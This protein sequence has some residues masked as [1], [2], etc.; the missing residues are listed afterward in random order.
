MT[1]CLSLSSFSGLQAR[2]WIGIHVLDYIVH[3][4]ISSYQTDSQITRILDTSVL[5]IMPLVNP[6]G[7]EYSRSELD[8]RLWRKNRSLLSS[9]KFA[10]SAAVGVNLD[11]NFPAHWG[12]IDGREGAE[13][14]NPLSSMFR[15]ETP[16]SEKEVQAI[17]H[18]FQESRPRIVAALDLRSYGPAILRP[19][20]S[21]QTETPFLSARLLRASQTV[22]S[23]IHTLHQKDYD[24]AQA[25]AIGGPVYGS[26]LD[27]AFNGSTNASSSSAYAF[28]IELRDGH[29]TQ[30]SQLQDQDLQLQQPQ[31][32]HQQQL[33]TAKQHREREWGG[34][35]GS[36]SQIQP[37]GDEVLKG[38]LW[39]LRFTLDS[40]LKS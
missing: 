40:P 13:L 32:Q 36:C 35:V 9:S 19:L 38:L 20:S 39:L 17:V 4:I 8:R 23:L 3:E 10:S 12:P 27:F 22:S 11:R 21:M 30:N 18:W 1:P 34:L 28:A 29:F 37:T 5:Y 33:S 2:D 15:G 6:D 16:G 25:G 31:R 26:W 7:Y 14:I 24:V